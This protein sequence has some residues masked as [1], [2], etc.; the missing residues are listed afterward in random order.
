MTVVEFLLGAILIVL[1]AL[2]FRIGALY[3]KIH[4]NQMD[5]NGFYQNSFSQREELLSVQREYLDDIAVN[6]EVLKNAVEDMK[7][8]SDVFYKYKLPNKDERE[9]LD[10]IVVE[11][12]VLS[13][14]HK[15]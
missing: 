3:K 11:N 14:M 15:D 9:E 6:I 10:R 7:F 13:R 5:S 2:F 12:T 1:I 8:V 4:S